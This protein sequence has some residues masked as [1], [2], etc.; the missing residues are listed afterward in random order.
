MAVAQATNA[1]AP[2]SKPVRQDLVLQ[3]AVQAALP[4]LATDVLI[5]PVG[6][7]AIVEG[8]VNVVTPVGEEIA[9]ALVV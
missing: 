3:V 2:L 6:T 9:K 7:S 4:L 5:P 8:K 1:P